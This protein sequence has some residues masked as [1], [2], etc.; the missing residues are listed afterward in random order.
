MARDCAECHMVGELGNEWEGVNTGKTPADEAEIQGG[1]DGARDGSAKR[2]ARPGPIE[3][4]RPREREPEV[5]GHG[6]GEQ[7]PVRAL[8]RQH[9][10]AGGVGGLERVATGRERVRGRGDPAQRCGVQG[11]SKDAQDRRIGLRA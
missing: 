10:G 11:G 3:H 7:L 1:D 5:E 9:D 8:T 2:A 4:G 6:G